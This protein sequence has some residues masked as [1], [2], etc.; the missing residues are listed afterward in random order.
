MK[1]TYPIFFLLV[2]FFS[3]LVKSQ[4]T[5]SCFTNYPAEISEGLD[6]P[7]IQYKN[8]TDQFEYE[9]SYAYKNSEVNFAGTYIIATWG[10][11]SPCQSHAIINTQNGVAN[12]IPFTTSLGMLYQANSSLLIVNPEMNSEK[13]SMPFLIGETKFFHF[14]RDSL[15]EIPSNQIPSLCK[16]YQ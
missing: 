14:E 3:P 9:I 12:F 16:K 10:C 15:K 7:S 6:K 13:E 4:T 11:G 1:F 8:G 5:D 2:I